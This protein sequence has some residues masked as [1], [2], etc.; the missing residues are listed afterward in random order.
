MEWN[1]ME[2]NGMETRYTTLYRSCEEDNDMPHIYATYT[3]TNTIHAA[4]DGFLTY[5]RDNS[6]DHDHDQ[7]L[8]FT[9]MHYKS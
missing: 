2:W 1:G 3:N 7:D 8:T 6:V 9:L 4:E 5:I